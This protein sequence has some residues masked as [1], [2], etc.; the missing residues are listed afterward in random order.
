MSKEGKNNED[1][2]S[3]DDITFEEQVAML[4]GC[5]YTVKEM[6]VYFS[7]VTS[8]KQFIEKANDPTSIIY[9][10][11]QRGKLKTGF[12][13][14]NQQRALAE[15]GNIT[16][17]QVFEKLKESKKVEEVINKIWFGI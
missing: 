2:S 3:I 15:S 8:P 13:I 10:A 9:L 11:I 12:Q 4:A 7:E 5:N 14:A 16:A 1:L 6:S 17:V